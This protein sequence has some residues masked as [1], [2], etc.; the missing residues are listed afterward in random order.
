M[1]Q[2]LLSTF[3]ASCKNPDQLLYLQWLSKFASYYIETFPKHIYNYRKKYSNYL[4]FIGKKIETQRLMG[5][6]N[7]C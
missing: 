2:Y 4:C 5:L 7:P 6:S 3:A 1:Q